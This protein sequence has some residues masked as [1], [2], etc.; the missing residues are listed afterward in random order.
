MAP[1]SP[2][3]PMNKAFLGVATKAS[4]E[5]ALIVDVNEGSPAA[6]AG[7]KEEDIITQVNKEKIEGCRTCGL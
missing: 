7:L 6:K 3:G 5:G 4:S 1:A 2:L